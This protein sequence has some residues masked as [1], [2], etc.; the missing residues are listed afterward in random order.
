[1][2]YVSLT[3]LAIFAASVRASAIADLK[4]ATFDYFISKHDVVMVEFFAPW[5]V[6]P[7]LL[8]VTPNFHPCSADPTSRRVRK[9]NLCTWNRC[10]VCGDLE[11]M[12]QQTALTHH[13]TKDIAFARVNC[14]EEK[15]LC[16][17]WFTPIIPTFRV[18]KG[19][20]ENE[21]YNGPRTPG[22]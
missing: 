13:T 3:A 14:D 10:S 16:N 7:S 2:F 17:E 1:M 21:V 19:L 22:E 15:D 20:E 9:T 11:P 18:F 6:L 8:Y 12:Y 5:L 4:L